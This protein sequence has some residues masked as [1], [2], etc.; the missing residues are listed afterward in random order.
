MHRS[1]EVDL[2]FGVFFGTS[3]NMPA[4]LDISDAKERLRYRPQDRLE[5][6]LS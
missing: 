2:R 4:V 6:H 1:L 3:D 5:N